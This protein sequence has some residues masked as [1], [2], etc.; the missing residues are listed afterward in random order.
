MESGIHYKAITEP[1]GC[2]PL[3]CSPVLPH[4][5]GCGG[6]EGQKGWGAAAVE[7]TRSTRRERGLVGKAGKEEMLGW[8]YPHNSLPPPHPLLSPKNEVSGRNSHEMLW[9][10]VMCCSNLYQLL[11]PHTHTPSLSRVQCKGR[12]Q[13]I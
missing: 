11:W 5:M 8:G 2:P 3:S 9:D 7:C 12:L 1:A 13:S 10:S 4:P 6:A